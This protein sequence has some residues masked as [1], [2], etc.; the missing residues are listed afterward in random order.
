M[1]T[2][3]FS[4]KFCPNYCTIVASGTIDEATLVLVDV[5]RLICADD[6]VCNR[7][8]NLELPWFW[9]K[10][11]LDGI[12][13][14]SEVKNCINQDPLKFTTV[15]VAAARRLRFSDESLSSGALAHWCTFCNWCTRLDGTDY[16][17]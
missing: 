3:A 12:K 1:S 13:I 7:N 5:V 8:A 16:K 11:S 17:G 9:L 14:I 6:V 2:C 15:K 10:C 4:A